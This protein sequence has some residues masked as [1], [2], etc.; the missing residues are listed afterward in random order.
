M[1][2]LE[3]YT[4]GSGRCTLCGN[5]GVI[6]TRP[7][8]KSPTGATVGR[9]N[10]CICPNGRGLKDERVPLSAALEARKSF[11]DTEDA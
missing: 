7:T 11:R 6:D 9:L 5:S 1:L 8:A 2:W 3:E 10:Y 4:N